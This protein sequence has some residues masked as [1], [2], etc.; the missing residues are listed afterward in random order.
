MRGEGKVVQQTHKG[1]GDN[2]GGDK[3]VNTRYRMRVGLLV[4][5]I[6]LATAAAPFVPDWLPKP[7][8]LEGF[9]A[10][11]GKKTVEKAKVYY[12]GADGKREE[13]F[14]DPAGK[15]RFRILQSEEVNGRILPG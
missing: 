14:T 12:T 9:V 7:I 11:S 3:I 5:T 4:V 15:F 6:L 2:V 13:T 10:S 8:P 1:T